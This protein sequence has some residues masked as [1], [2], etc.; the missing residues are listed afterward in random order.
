M[1]YCLIR[2][3]F[4]WNSIRK[5]SLSAPRSKNFR[6]YAALRYRLHTAVSWEVMP[7]LRMAS[8]S[9]SGRSQRCRTPAASSPP[10]WTQIRPFRRSYSMITPQ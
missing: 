4:P 9:S 8:R 2:R 3:S 5:L 1:S 10:Q 7:L 6:R